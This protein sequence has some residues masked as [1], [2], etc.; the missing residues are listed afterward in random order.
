MQRVK[1]LPIV[2]N[3]VADP[4]AAG[5]G[6][7]NESHLPNVTGTYLIGA[8]DQMVPMI[9]TY[10]PKARVL[11]TVYVPAEVNMVS[12]KAVLERAARTA[13]F[14][15][16]AVPANATGEVADAA[17]ALVAAKVDG[18]CQLPGNLTV[19]AFPTI[20]QVA[21]RGRVPIF[22][23]QSSQASDAVLTLARDYYDSGREAAKL[24]ARIMH[25]DSPATLPFVGMADVQIIINQTAARDAGLTSPAAVVAKAQKVID[26]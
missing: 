24:A 23:F 5:A 15:L 9:R 4:I 7:S 25:G 13:G 18:I 14:E 6:T 10:L 11:G 12:Q 1:Q 22:A 2:F 26:H 16:K 20:A 19:A 3:Y 17:L 8:Y 21:H